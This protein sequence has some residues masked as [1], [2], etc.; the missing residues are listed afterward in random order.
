MANADDS[1]TRRIPLA[2]PDVGEREVELVT[3]VLRSDILALGPFAPRFEEAIAAAVG[4]REAIACSSGTAGL[5]MGVRALGIGD[6]DEVLTTPFSFVA[7]SNCLLY[8]RAIPRFVDI[9]EGSLGMDPD[10]IGAATTART[11]AICRSMSSVARAGL[12]ISRQRPGSKA[13]PSSRTPVKDWDPLSAIGRWAASGTSP[14]LPS[15][16]TNRSRPARGEWSSPT[17]IP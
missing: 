4:R 13:G 5:H 7:S 15:I 8:E 6:G 11:K 17:T 14:S 9:E 10:R 2:R 12:G 16:Q 1:P 3:Q